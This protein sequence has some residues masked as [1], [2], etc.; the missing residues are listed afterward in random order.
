VEVALPKREG[1]DVISI[2]MKNELGEWVKYKP[3]IS[4]KWNYD[5]TCNNCKAH[6]LSNHTKFCPARGAEMSEE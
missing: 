3:R 6:V 4:S 2:V 5:G 1:K